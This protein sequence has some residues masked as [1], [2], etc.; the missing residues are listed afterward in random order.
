MILPLGDSPNPPTKPLVTYA[1]LA[2]NVAVYL[3]V[4]V[5]LSMTPVHPGDPRVLEYLNAV[6]RSLPEGVPLD[7]VLRGISA[8][9]LFVFEHG[10]RPAAPH[11]GPLF[12]SLFLHGGLLHLF[13]N[14]LILWIY[15]DNVEHR[16]GGPLYLLAYLATGPIATLTHAA[17]DSRSE[18]PLVGASGAISGILGFYFLWFP[19]NRVRLLVLIFPFFLDVV[20][21]PARFVLGLFLLVDN[22]LP[23]L[24]TRGTAASG[25]AYGAHIG[26]F[27]AG[28]IAKAMDVREVA[29]RPREYKRV[30]V[31]PPPGTPAR[32]AIQKALHTGR[33]GE[34]AQL[35]FAL[36]PRST[37][38]L[39]GP[40]ELLALAEWLRDTGQN[41]AALT[42]YRRY[43]RDYP[44]SPRTAEAHLGAGLLLLDA[45]DQ[46]TPAYQHFLDVLD[47]NPPP[48]VEAAARHGL[49]RILARQKFRVGRLRHP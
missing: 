26:G 24:I 29:G 43:L 39:L 41:R 1:L 13:G 23:F 49:E 12:S 7:V 10:F 38:R 9:D 11:L 25:V 40:D 5:P 20:T 30:A 2:A 19:R 4:T 6:A 46:P 8:Y 34:A 45:F 48:S 22:L 44:A 21:V 36:D 15:G 47:C 31:I 18:L 35:Y 42:A 28:W 37:Q 27:L 33:V 3:L 17:F 16:L 32:D 14:M